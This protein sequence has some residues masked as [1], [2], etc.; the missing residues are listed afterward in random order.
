MGVHKK[1]QFLRGAGGGRVVTKN[2]YI[3]GNCL[4]R[5][6]GQFADLR[7][8]QRKRGGWCF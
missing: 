6:H 1:I 4:K 3:V 2:Q 8:A 7:G 5:R